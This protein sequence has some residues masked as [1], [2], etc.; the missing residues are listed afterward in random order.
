MSR[1]DGAILIEFEDFHCGDGIVAQ[2]DVGQFQRLQEGR[3]GVAHAD[4]SL[5]GADENQR[6]T[7]FGGGPRFA[8]RKGVTAQ[9]PR[10]DAA[11]HTW[12]EFAHAPKSDNDCARGRLRAVENDFGSADRPGVD[13]QV[14]APSEAALER[15]IQLCLAAGQ[16]IAFIVT[17]GNRPTREG[18]IAVYHPQLGLS[19]FRA[20][21]LAHVA[22]GRGEFALAR[23]TCATS[24][25]NA[26][27]S[28]DA[29]DVSIGR[30]ASRDVEP[31]ASRSA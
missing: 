21:E 14:A 16:R 30:F 25:G 5:S 27:A 10:E 24:G 9:R 4:T 31:V 2:R 23:N 20:G 18:K 26:I 28:D 7:Q 17:H 3:Y 12:C 29:L 1:L 19:R 13:A 15:P 8:N 11:K 22:D 6:D